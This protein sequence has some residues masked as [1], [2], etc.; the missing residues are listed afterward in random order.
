[1]AFPIIVYLFMCAGAGGLAGWWV[2]DYTTKNL[3][4]E[5]EK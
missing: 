4:V 2:G 3:K 1:M 5:K